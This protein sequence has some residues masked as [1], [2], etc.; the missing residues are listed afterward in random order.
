MN[1][2]FVMFIWHCFTYGIRKRLQSTGT[3]GNESKKDCKITHVVFN[4]NISNCDYYVYSVLV[5]TKYFH[6]INLLSLTRGRNH[7]DSEAQRGEVTHPPSR[8]CNSRECSKSGLSLD[9]SS[10]R[11]LSHPF[12][13]SST[14]PSPGPSSMLILCQYALIAQTPQPRSSLL[15][16]DLSVASSFSTYLY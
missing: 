2:Y 5:F 13:S 3:F 10:P 7:Y 11:P 16:K 15:G 14:P 8:D 9:L 12:L 1:L 4:N 6:I